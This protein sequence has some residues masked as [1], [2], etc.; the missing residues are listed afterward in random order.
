M[1]SVSRPTLP[2]SCAPC[3]V[4]G[5]CRWAQINARDELPIPDKVKFDVDYVKRQSFG[6]DLKI[7]FLTFLK[8]LRRDG[9][10]H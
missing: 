6:L 9:V 4:A 10:A 8:V 5:R 3:S 7:I 2:P 1:V